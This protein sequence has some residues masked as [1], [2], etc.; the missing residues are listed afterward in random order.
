M[1][2]CICPVVVPAQLRAFVGDGAKAKDLG[3]MVAGGG[4]TYVL[5]SV[6]S[7]LLH[8]LEHCIL[9]IAIKLK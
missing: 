5:C 2:M 7:L 3:F 8:L 4:C 9:W 1:Y 6:C